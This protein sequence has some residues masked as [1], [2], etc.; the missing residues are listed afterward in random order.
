MPQMRIEAEKR[1]ADDMRRKRD[2]D[3]S[4][5]VVQDAAILH[6]FAEQAQPLRRRLVPGHRPALRERM[7]LMSHQNIMLVIK[8]NAPHI[9]KRFV[10]E[11]GDA[12]VEFERVER[13][14]DGAGN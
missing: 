5:D 12:A 11:I 9:L 3:R 4:R 8:R 7:I 2:S 13:P 6:V 1:I 14:L 10:L